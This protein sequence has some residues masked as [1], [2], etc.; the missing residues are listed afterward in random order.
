M[1]LERKSI[2]V[3]LE[4]ISYMIIITYT[5]AFNCFLIKEETLQ[6]YFPAYPDALTQIS[7]V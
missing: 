7:L 3:T 6:E 2:F 5:F 1:Y 4:Y